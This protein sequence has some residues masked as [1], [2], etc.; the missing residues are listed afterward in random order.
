[1]INRNDESRMIESASGFGGSLQLTGTT[2]DLIVR[3]DG[4]A[5]Q[6]PLIV[7]VAVDPV[8]PTLLGKD[9]SG[10]VIAPL[11]ILA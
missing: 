6:I 1:M 2:G 7:V 8:D 3:S 11:T 9:S 5:G 10:R 4:T